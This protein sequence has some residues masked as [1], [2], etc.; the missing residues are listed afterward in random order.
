MNAS[1]ATQSLD[2]STPILD[3]LQPMP[4]RERAQTDWYE[5]ASPVLIGLVTFLLI[6]LAASGLPWLRQR[7]DDSESPQMGWIAGIL[8]LLAVAVMTIVVHELG[9]FFAGKWVGFRFRYICIGPIQLD[10]SFKFSYSRSRGTYRLGAVSF[11]PAEMRNHPWKYLIM[12]IAG[13]AAN[14]VCALVF[15]L[16]FDKSFFLIIFAGISAYLGTINLVPS[17]KG[18]SATDGFKILTIL[19][20]R[21]KHE[22]TLAVLQILNEMKSGIDYEALSPELIHQATAVRDKSWM[23]AMA[24]SIA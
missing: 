19:F 15:L 12:V 23:T 6:A 9:H 17:R 3:R 4:D 14:I 7:V 5:W 8:L 11:F 13:P 16:P 10:H 2:K 24:Y 21:I 18:F 20:K 1:P 22:R